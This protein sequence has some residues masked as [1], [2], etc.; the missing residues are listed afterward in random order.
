MDTGQRECDTF[1]M[2][3]QMYSVCVCMCVCV[4]ARTGACVNKVVSLTIQNNLL[5]HQLCGVTTNVILSSFYHLRIGH[6]YRFLAFFFFFFF[7][8]SSF[9]FSF[10]FFLP[11]PSV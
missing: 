6:I 8:F 7:F 5:P 2:S 9:F 1:H 10:F 4:C 11:F 3:S